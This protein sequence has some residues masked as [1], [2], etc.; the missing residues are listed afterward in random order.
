M[1]VCV[2]LCVCVHVHNVCVH[3]HVLYITYIGKK[4]LDEGAGDKKAKAVTGQQQW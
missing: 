3:I 1:C 4:S 2:Y